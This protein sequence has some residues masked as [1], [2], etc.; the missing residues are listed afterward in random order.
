MLESVQTAVITYKTII[1]SLSFTHYSHARL[2]G[3]S[4]AASYCDAGSAVRASL[5]SAKFCCTRTPR[6]TVRCASK[7]DDY[8]ADGADDDGLIGDAKGDF[9]FAVFFEPTRVF[10]KS[11]PTNDYEVEV[12]ER[13]AMYQNV[14]LPNVQQEGVSTRV[15]GHASGIRSGR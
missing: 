2:K 7:H 4:S 3:S 15:A 9:D 14:L 8:Y 10:E 6:S 13:A 1:K 12:H 11:V 5:A